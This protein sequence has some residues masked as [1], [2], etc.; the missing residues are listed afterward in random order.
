MIRRTV[1]ALGLLACVA[2]P[3]SAQTA[4]GLR[5]RISL[6][7]GGQLQTERLSQSFSLDEYVEPAPVRA[8]LPKKTIASFDG[9]VATNLYGPIGVGFAVSY[10]NNRGDASVGAALPHPFYFDRRRE[11]SGRARVQHSELVAHLNL[12]YL[13]TSPK[14]ELL[15]SAGPSIFR[16]D[17]DLVV[18]VDYIE[19]YPYDVATFSSAIIEQARR[20]KVGYNVTADVTWKASRNW[21]LGVLVRFA[22]AHVEYPGIGQSG[23]IKTAVGGVQAAGGIRLMY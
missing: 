22:R 7:V 23:V 2:V 4:W 21:G 12:V 17:Q 3:A 5:N 14:L 11:I 10:L 18:D 6:S 20:T 9:G 1:V 13:V 8:D 19:A 16:T 15:V